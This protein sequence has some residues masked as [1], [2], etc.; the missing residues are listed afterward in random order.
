MMVSEE[1]APPSLSEEAPIDFGLDLRMSPAPAAGILLAFAC[2]A[3]WVKPLDALLLSTFVI[4]LGTLLLV[5]W[6]PVYAKWA[7]VLGLV[8]AIMLLRTTQTAP[9]ALTLLVIPTGLAA[10]MLNLRVTSLITLGETIL[11]Q[12]FPGMSGGT[13]S[14]EESL[15]ALLAIW[16]TL[17]IMTGVFRPVYQFAQ[18]AARYYRHTRQQLQEALNTTVS[19][20]ETLKELARASRQ[21]GLS[22]ERLASL[23]LIAEEAEKTKVAFVSKVSHEL[24]TPLNMI[25]GLVDLMVKSPDIYGQAFPPAAFEDLKVVYRN[26]EHLSSLINDVLDLTQAES[27]RLTLH[28]ERVDINAVVNEAIGVVQPLLSKKSLSMHIHVPPDLPR[29][30]CDRTRIRQVILNLLSNAARF[31]D[32][33]SITIRAERKT[34]YIVVSVADTGPGIPPQDREHIFVP[35]CQGTQALWLDK[36]GSGLGLSISKQFVEL[37]G[38]RIW[39]DSQIGKGTTFSFDLPISQPVVPVVTPNR[40]IAEDWVWLEHNPS[41]KLPD[42]RPKPRLVVC[43]STGELSQSISH[44]SDELDVVEVRHPA[45][46]IEQLRHLPAHAVILNACTPEELLPLVEQAR[47]DITN[48][49]VIGCVIPSAHQPIWEAHALDYLIKPVTRDRLTQAL[50]RAGTAMKR[51]L[52]VDDDPDVQKLLTRMLLVSNSSLEVEAVASGEQALQTLRL[53]PPDL[54]L[55]D[56]ILPDMDGWQL[57][58]LKNEQAAIRDIPVIF[59]SAQ[60]PSADPISSPALVVGIDKGVSLSKLVRCSLALSATLLQPDPGPDV[61]PG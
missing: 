37:H 33:G 12:V 59:L 2:I 10:A 21:L 13:M 16:A 39:F 9:G 6:K 23:R 30:Y 53:H 34:E 40:W 28:K 55:L 51:I 38:G 48:T 50:Q 22:N 49:P 26:C 8:F 20:D 46:V 52:V 58:R 19:L 32:Q 42:L 45:E 17:G 15:I 3:V 60:D 61:K 43:D 1:Q 29:I 24:R 4:S 31:T 11:L 7:F 25:I 54:M 27:G 18:W 47:H 44:Y 14:P 56:V 5:L 41:G 57:L 36:G 35:F